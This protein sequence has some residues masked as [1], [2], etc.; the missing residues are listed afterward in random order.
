MAITSSSDRFDIDCWKTLADPWN[1]VV[2]VG[3]SM[4]FA[5]SV[6]FDTASPSEIPGLTLNEIDTAGN[7]PM[8]FTDCGP[9]VSLKLTTDS[10]G[11]MPPPGALNEIF[12][13]VSACCWYCGSSSSSTRYWERWP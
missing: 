4:P 13:S 1:V 7:W 9:T 10:S 11:T 8:W 3:G 5:T 6:T 12:C 2:T